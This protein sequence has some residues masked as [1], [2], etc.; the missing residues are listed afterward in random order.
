MI[1]QDADANALIL[2]LADGQDFL[3]NKVVVAYVL[4][5]DALNSFIGIQEAVIV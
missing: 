4:Q 3:I 2:Y 1:F 5:G